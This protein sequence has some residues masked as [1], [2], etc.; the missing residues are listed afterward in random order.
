MME[1]AFGNTKERIHLVWQM[2]SEF[3]AFSLQVHNPEKTFLHKFSDLV[4]SGRLHF[5][6]DGHM[7]I[8]SL[9]RYC[10]VEFIINF[11]DRDPVHCE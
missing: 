6:P 1:L 11:S 8:R 10:F 3:L 9:G 4:S 2:N 7:Y 5:D